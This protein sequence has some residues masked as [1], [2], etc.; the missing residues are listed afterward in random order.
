MQWSEKATESHPGTV[1]HYVCKNHDMGCKKG[2][3][4]GCSK[5]PTELNNLILN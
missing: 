1:L 3:I 5:Y 2:D 4:P